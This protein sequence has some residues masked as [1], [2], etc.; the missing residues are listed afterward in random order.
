M[1]FLFWV[2]WLNAWSHTSHKCL[3]TVHGNPWEMR[4]VEPL[5]SFSEVKYLIKLL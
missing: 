5:L 1:K 3:H 4:V 2:L